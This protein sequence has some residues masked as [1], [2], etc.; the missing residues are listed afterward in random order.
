VKLA[1]EGKALLYYS[2]ETEE[3]ARLCHRVLVMREGRIVSALSGPDATAESIVAG[4]AQREPV[5][6]AT[7]VGGSV[8]EAM[9]TRR[10][11]GVLA[12]NTPLIL[13]LAI[14]LGLTSL[15]IGLFHG[16][17]NRLPGVFEWTSIVNTALPIA[18]VA[19][20]QS[21][22]VITRGIDLSVGGTIDV[23]NSLAATQM[24]ASLA[25]MAGW[26]LG[27][28]A[29]G[30][31]IGA[32][33]GALI[34][35]ARLQPILVTLATLAILQG[36][37]IRILPEP[38]GSIPPSY[39]T[40]LSSSSGPWSLFF[41]LGIALLWLVLRR[42][43]I[44]VRIFAIGNDE[45]A[46]RAHGMPVRRV[47][48]TA[49]ALSGLLA[50]ASGLFLAASTTAWPIPRRATSTSLP[51][52]RPSCSEA[53]ASP[54][55]AAA[56]LAASPARSRSRCSRTCSSSRASIRFYQSFFQGLFL[57]IA[58]L[59]GALLGRLL[60]SRHETAHGAASRS[61]WPRRRTP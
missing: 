54:V 15:Y 39:S 17:L 5:V 36:V 1:G 46:A 26:S 53:S 49:Y 35:Y 10:W 28:L 42:L 11:R 16:Q 22:V 23:S 14:L 18:L 21:V 58:V 3:I 29:L 24:H 52:S 57:F 13:A 61:E 56:L 6:I 50:A 38:G 47:K 8:R 32:A 33:N 4:V 20:G 2:S 7:K 48:V 30:A 9:T 43:T 27:I 25:S 40:A 12:Q 59:L 34:A 45:Y 51:R 37:A 60:R 55:V 44:G 31:A 19:V 41:I